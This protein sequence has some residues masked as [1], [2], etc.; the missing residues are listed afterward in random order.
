MKLTNLLWTALVIILL[1]MGLQRIFCSDMLVEW[2]NE[3]LPLSRLPL[4]AQL[5][6]SLHAF[7]GR[8]RDWRAKSSNPLWKIFYTSE[9]VIGIIIITFFIGAYTRIILR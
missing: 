6:L 3:V 9:M 2:D 1:F 8:A 7:L 5:L 4:H